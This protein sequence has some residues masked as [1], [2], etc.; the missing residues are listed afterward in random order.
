MECAGYSLLDNRRDRG[1]FGGFRLG[2]ALRPYGFD[3]VWILHSSP[4]C[5][6]LPHGVPVSVS[7]SGLDR[8]AGRIS[9]IAAQPFTESTEALGD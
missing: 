7:G 5:Y 3:T 9:D 2:A 6:G 8:L 4:Q 1:P